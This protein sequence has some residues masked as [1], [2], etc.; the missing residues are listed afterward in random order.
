[1]IM[2]AIQPIT[3]GSSMARLPGKGAP[4]D[5][6]FSNVRGPLTRVYETRPPLY[7]LEIM[8]AV[9]VRARIVSPSMPLTWHRL[10]LARKSLVG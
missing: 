4:A 8:P 2:A 9:H 7:F 1:M 10:K 5:S 3:L 6:E